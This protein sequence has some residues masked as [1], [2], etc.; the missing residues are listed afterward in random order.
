MNLKAITRS[1]IS[2]LRKGKYY[3]ITLMGVLSIVRFIDTVRWLPGAWAVGRREKG[4]SLFN[5]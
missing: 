4:L 3:R 1:E 5:G 2:Q